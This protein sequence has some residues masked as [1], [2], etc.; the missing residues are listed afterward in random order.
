MIVVIIPSAAVTAQGSRKGLAGN[1]A[2]SRCFSLWHA[3]L[4]SSW[5]GAEGQD[6]A[7]SVLEAPVAQQGV[8]ATE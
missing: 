2:V 3:A 7:G 5:L 8:L 1:T 6:L 4:E